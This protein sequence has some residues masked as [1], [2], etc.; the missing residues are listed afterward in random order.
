MAADREP[1]N[2]WDRAR[3]HPD[4]PAVVEAGRVALTYGE[5][6]ERVNKICHALRELRVVRGDRVAA[7]MT[8]TWEFTGLQL[9]A[10]QIGLYFTAINRHLAPGEVAYVLENSAA[11]VLVVGPDLVE[12]AEQALTPAGTVRAFST[13]TSAF[14]R[15]SFEALWTRQPASAPDDRTAGARLFYSS[16]TT[17]RPKGILQP[18]PGATPEVVA[19]ALRT[20]GEQLG[21]RP[22]AGVHYAVAPLYHS[23]PNSMMLQALHR[24]HQV[25]LTPHR[26]FDAE[27]VLATMTT[28]G[29]TDTFMVPTMFHRFLR[30]PDDARAAFD[31]SRLDTVVHSGAGCPVA[32]KR[33]MLDWWG[34][35]FVEF[36]GG[37]ETGIATIVDSRTWLEAPGTVGR[38]RAGYDVKIVDSAGESL[39]PGTEGQIAIKGGPAFCY[40]GDPEK[41]AAA[42]V[43]GYCLLGDIGRVDEAGFLF[44]LDRRADLILSGG[45]NIYPA[46]VEAALLSHP[47]VTDAVVFGVPDEEW[48]AVVSA[49]VAWRGRAADQE[50]HEELD[51]HLR[52]SIAS[53]KRPRYLHFV[54][55]VPRMESGKVNRSV[56]R[57]RFLELHTPG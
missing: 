46:E 6:A 57:T 2:F 28:H 33:A 34:S 56:A 55:E 49:L 27:A 23:G 51:R 9:A 16:G 4:R 37:T 30:A 47:A 38:A 24:G 32:T 36:Y 1:W 7:M 11:S 35:V 54:D 8:N 50:A 29:V 41:T 26:P 22:G 15:E 52:T 25:L 18:L 5:L 45:V 3:S 12:V 42:V 13:T 17:G 43:D 10:S 44:V 53:F 20:T 14:G 39:P 48:G 19:E 31:P 21:L 40:L